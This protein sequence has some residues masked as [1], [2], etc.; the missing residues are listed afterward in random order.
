[1]NA[2][3]VRTRQMHL[4]RIAIITVA[5]VMAAPIAW[6]GEKLGKNFEDEYAG[7][8]LRIPDRWSTVPIEPFQPVEV[9]L[10]QGD[11]QLGVAPRLEVRYWKAGGIKTEWDDTPMPELSEIEKARFMRMKSAAGSFTEWMTRFEKTRDFKHENEITIRSKDGTEG[12]LIEGKSRVDS[13]HYYIATF[14]KDE[15]EYGILYRANDRDWE[16]A[17]R[18]FQGSIK[19][20]RILDEVGVVDNIK[21]K[22]FSGTD[23]EQERRIKAR[24]GLPSDWYALD[25]EHYIFV[26]NAEP[27]LLRD[28]SKRIENLRVNYFEKFFPPI[29]E[30][31]ALSIVRV[32][33]DRDSYLAY[34][35]PP[36]SAG[37]WWTLTEELVFYQDRNDLRGSFET[38]HHEA[39][40]QY[41]YY[42]LGDA[43]PHTWFNE[44]NA[45]Y[46]AGAKF[47]GGRFRI[48]KRPGRATAMKG[49]IA[50]GDV[51]P[52]AHLISMSQSE[53]YARNGR[54][55]P[56]GWALV[57]YLREE[58]GGNL[59]RIL[60]TYYET[61]K[62][63]LV[64]LRAGREPWLDENG[65]GTPSEAWLQKE[66]EKENAQP[67]AGK[68][69][70][71]VK[72]KS[73]VD[74]IARQYALTVAFEG[75]DL[76]ALEKAWLD[77]S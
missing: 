29:G 4:L 54:G 37:Y 42:A 7:Y 31:T 62:S 12:R 75:V 14:A 48:G 41:I 46:F 70:V 18:V 43:A 74:E 53:Y 5:V 30:I 24:I 64:N 51:F 26:S 13:Q 69:Q 61:L 35:A 8:A 2:T 47:S 55:Y 34:G 56:Q 60:P 6:A 23:E 20:F 28:L 68:L 39:F 71:N 22:N 40:H 44:G 17:S 32:C 25:T 16:D 76:D 36:G 52:L 57:Y 11:S 19:S 58:A 10:W 27:K 73:R 67:E 66:A 65:E 45:D 59:R 50:E 21:V 63:A 49:F 3:I 33:K 77:A 1:M 9:G 38:L 15:R 72:G